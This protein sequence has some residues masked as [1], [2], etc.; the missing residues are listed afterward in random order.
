MKIL[1]ILSWERKIS[2]C[3]ELTKTHETVFR[4]TLS[5]AVAYYETNEPRGEYVLVIEG[6]SREA[7]RE[8][9]VRSFDGIS[10][11]EHMKMYE[12]KGIDRKEAM[13]LVAR[14]R[15]ISKRDVYKMLVG[16][17]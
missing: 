5:Q 17:T 4:T 14:D 10:L 3:K 15:G 12:E 11:E 6:K 8:E 13:K 9:A 2:L 1:K 16:E 7:I